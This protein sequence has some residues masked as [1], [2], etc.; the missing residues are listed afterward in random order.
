MKSF[1][2]AEELD[3]SIVE[4]NHPDRSQ[5]SAE[6]EQFDATWDDTDPKQTL[7]DVT[8]KVPRGDLLAVVG[9]VGSGKSSLLNAL[10][11]EVGKLQGR[12]GVN[13]KLAYVPQQAWIQ[14]M[15]VKDNILFGKPY[16]KQL[17]HKVLYAC[18]LVSDLKI[19]PHGDQTEI[20]E[21]GINLSGGQKARISLARAVYQN[22]DVYLLDDP[23]SAV[24]AHVGKHIFEKAR[25]ERQLE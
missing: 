3:M 2:V 6:M 23:L 17:Y 7:S 24:D 21:K 9:K 11:G 18:A 25:A 22:Y 20:G 19:L 15:T 13:G 5:I 10:L 4:R 1:F 16:N 8:L 14:N 12:I